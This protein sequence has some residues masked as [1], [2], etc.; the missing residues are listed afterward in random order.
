MEKEVA[1]GEG[2]A[3]SRNRTDCPSFLRPELSLRP[4]ASRREQVAE[5]VLSWV[6]EHRN[7]RTMV[8]VGEEEKQPEPGLQQG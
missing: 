8:W 1:A 4:S 5:L 6:L 3:P 2:P 7:R